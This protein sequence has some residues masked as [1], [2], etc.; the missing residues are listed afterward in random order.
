MNKEIVYKNE[1]FQIIG[2]CMKIH[3]NLGAGFLE[4]VYS[5]VLAKELKKEGIPFEQEKKLDLYY[6][7]QKLSK[8]FKADFI[9]FEDIIL[10]IKSVNFLAEAFNKQ[11][12]NYL[13][14][15]NKRLGILINFGQSSL[16]YKR[17][18]NSKPA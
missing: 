16:T 6:E 8:Y 17:I 14:A 4:S 15:T 18:V 13:R 10:E 12:L 2:I 3:S 5:E 7:D 1:S 9:C 11:L